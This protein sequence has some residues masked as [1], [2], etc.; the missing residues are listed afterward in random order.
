MGEVAILQN[1]LA[2]DVQS[3]MASIE[4]LLEQPGPNEK[5]KPDKEVEM[6]KA[7][8]QKLSEQGVTYNTAPSLSI[9]GNEKPQV[10]RPGHTSQRPAEVKERVNLL[11]KISSYS[12]SS[13]DT[14]SGHTPSSGKEK[15]VYPRVDN[16]PVN[17]SGWYRAFDPKS[18]RPY[19]FNPETR[20]TK[21]ERPRGHRTVPKAGTETKKTLALNEALCL[22]C[23]DSLSVC[24]CDPFKKKSNSKQRL[25]C[26]KCF[27]IPCQ[28]KKL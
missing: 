7:R 10:T 9:R 1:K 13:Y 12:R 27:D 2:M 6:W 19:L 8:I 25:L 14:S 15:N 24:K 16:G 20:E 26:N 4:K 22:S 21:W 28:C 3:R 18:G 5:P 23:F 11:S 17:S